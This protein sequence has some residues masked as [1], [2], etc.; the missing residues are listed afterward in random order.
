MQQFDCQ[1]AIVVKVLSVIPPNFKQR[2]DLQLQT[3][4]R[5][6]QSLLGG[7]H[8]EN[9]QIYFFIYPVHFGELTIDMLLLTYF[10]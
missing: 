5:A 7:I 10:V 8:F 3:P 6:Q 1:C 2:A 9:E 4:H